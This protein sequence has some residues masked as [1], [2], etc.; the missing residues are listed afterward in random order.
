ML[1]SN[2][3]K[4]ISLLVFGNTYLVGVQTFF[5]RSMWFPNK[6]SVKGAKRGRQYIV[7]IGLDSWQRKIYCKDLNK[8]F[9]QIPDRYF[10]KLNLI[11]HDLTNRQTDNC[12]FVC[13]DVDNNGDLLRDGKHLLCLC[14]FPPITQWT[15]VPTAASATIN[16]FL[17]FEEKTF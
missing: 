9:A 5:S 1:M 14:V 12:L 17:I 8:N 16:L 10:Q 2:H 3:G 6:V 15:N 7:M 4:F 11:F 13:C